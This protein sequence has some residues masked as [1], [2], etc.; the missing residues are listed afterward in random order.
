ML[1]RVRK[2]SMLAAILLSCLLVAGCDDVRV[3]GSVSHSSFSS[4]SGGFG[5]SVTVG[6]RIR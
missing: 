3:Y 2:S 5:T 6:G 1:E 4:H